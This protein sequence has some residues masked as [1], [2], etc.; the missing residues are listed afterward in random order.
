MS[1]SKRIDNRKKD[2][3]ILCK[4]PTQGLE[5][6]LSTEKLYSV[7]FSEE[8]IKF[9]LSFYYNG[10]NSYVMVFGTLSNVNPLEC[11]SMNNQECK[12]RAEIVNLNINELLFYPFSIKTSKCGGSCNNIN[13]PY[14]KLCVHDVVENLSIKVFN[15]M[16]RANETGI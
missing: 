7:Y 16:S 8:N 15:L 14:A 6:I 9:C 4:E 2:I 13:D 11:F 10:A 12:V 1:L 3:L 5:H